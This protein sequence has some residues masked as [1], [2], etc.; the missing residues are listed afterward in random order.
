MSFFFLFFFLSKSSKGGENERKKKQST[1]LCIWTL[2]DC[3]AVIMRKT[4]DDDDRNERAPFATL[5]AASDEAWEVLHVDRTSEECNR[6][7]TKR[8]ALIGPN[9]ELRFSN[10]VVGRILMAKDNV[11]RAKMQTA[12]LALDLPSGT[13][14]FLLCF[15]AARGNG[16]CARLRVREE[17]EHASSSFF[18]PFVFYHYVQE[19]VPTFRECRTP[20]TEKGI[21]GSFFVLETHTT[22]TLVMTSPLFLLL[23][24]F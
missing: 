19:R 17:M 7:G 16:F 22:F 15:C 5:V 23:S 8:C 6:V 10:A 13:F 20:E 12:D 18:L 14:G 3:D 4:D 11:T 1:P 21:A 2:D 9:V 24:F